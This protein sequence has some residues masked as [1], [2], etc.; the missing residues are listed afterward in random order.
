ML[1]EL[2]ASYVNEPQPRTVYRALLSHGGMQRTVVFDDN[3]VVDGRLALRPEEID[4]APDAQQPGA[5][6]GLARFTDDPVKVATYLAG[7]IGKNTRINRFI[8]D[9]SMMTVEWVAPDKGNILLNQWMIIQNNISAP[10]DPTP[11]NMDKVC[12]KQPTAEAVAESLK[13]A[14]AQPARAHRI[15]QAAM[16]LLECEKA[17]TPPAWNLLGGDGKLETG[18]A[19]SQERFGF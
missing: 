14:M 8:I 1:V 3:G 11:P 16:L 5:A 9:P 19:L 6:L 18:V 17:G 13:R 2:D 7:A 10:D 15:R 4:D 12:A